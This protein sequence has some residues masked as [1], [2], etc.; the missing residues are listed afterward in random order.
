MD[1]KRVVRRDSVGPIEKRQANQVTIR[2][3]EQ[4]KTILNQAKPKKQ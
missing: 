1:Q 2:K 4:A 3:V